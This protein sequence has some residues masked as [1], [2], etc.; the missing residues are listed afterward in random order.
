MSPTRWGPAGTL[1]AYGT[2]G[3]PRAIRWLVTMSSCAQMACHVSGSSSGNSLAIRA[4]SG[5]G[6]RCTVRLPASLSTWGVMSLK[7]SVP[8]AAR[9]SGISLDPLL[10][11][12]RGARPL[13]RVVTGAPPF[14]RPWRA[15]ECA[16]TADAGAGRHGACASLSRGAATWARRLRSGEGSAS[17]TDGHTVPPARSSPGRWRSGCSG[18]GAG[19][20][21]G[22][23][24]AGVS[25]TFGLAA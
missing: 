13:V 16:R 8:A 23:S 25:A 2:T 4:T 7:P 1:V 19:S 6:A 11:S 5:Y 21:R 24:S 14:S 17:Y 15:N 9:M 18:R 22:A 20:G 10:R 12:G 3:I